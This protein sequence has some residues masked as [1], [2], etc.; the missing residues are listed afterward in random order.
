MG[1]CYYILSIL[2]DTMVGKQCLDTC[3]Y[4]KGFGNQSIAYFHLCYRR[5]IG[6]GCCMIDTWCSNCSDNQYAIRQ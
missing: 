1:I 6:D 4:A 3:N 2:V 5:V